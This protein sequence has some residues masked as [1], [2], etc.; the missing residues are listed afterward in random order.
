M[1]RCRSNGLSLFN[2]PITLKTLEIIADTCAS[3]DKPSSN[4]KSKHFYVLT[5][6][7]FFH[8]NK[9]N[10]WLFRNIF[11]QFLLRGNKHLF[12]FLCINTKLINIKPIFKSL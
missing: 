4:S 11:S 10:L 12:G 9:K 7:F 6:L 5:L 3:H 2:T 1:V 8:E